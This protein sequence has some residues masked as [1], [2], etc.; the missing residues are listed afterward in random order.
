MT[1]A[2]NTKITSKSLNK[3]FHEANPVRHSRQNNSIYDEMPSKRT[4]LLPLK[5]QILVKQKLNNIR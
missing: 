3:K 2:Y 4:N 1:N 5:N